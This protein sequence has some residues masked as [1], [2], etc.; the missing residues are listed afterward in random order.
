VLAAGQAARGQI[1]VLERALIGEA[2]RRSSGFMSR[3]AG[4]LLLDL[5]ARVRAS[6]RA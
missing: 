6:T 3:G 2:A 1:T 5:A 4:V